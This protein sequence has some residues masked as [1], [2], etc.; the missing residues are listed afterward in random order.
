MFGF[1]GS[2]RRRAAAV[3]E[4][5]REMKEWSRTAW[6]DHWH[7]SDMQDLQVELDAFLPDAMAQAQTNPHLAGSYSAMITRFILLGIGASKS[8]DTTDFEDALGVPM[9]IEVTR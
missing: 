7:A 9:P 3:E 5:L 2:R 8:H 4:G 1:L 6:L